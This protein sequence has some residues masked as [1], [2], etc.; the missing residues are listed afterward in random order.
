M[1]HSQNLDVLVLLSIGDDERRAGNHQLPSGWYSARWSEQRMMFEMFDRREDSLD[2]V[3]S[4]LK[5]V[6]GNVI[7]SRVKVRNRQ[8]GPRDLHRFRQRRADFFASK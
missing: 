5:I 3:L 1:Q 7:I 6:G 2:N 8:L 4:G